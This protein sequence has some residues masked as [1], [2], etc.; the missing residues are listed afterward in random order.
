MDESAGIVDV[1]VPGDQFRYLRTVDRPECGLYTVIIYTAQQ[2]AGRASETELVTDLF[3]DHALVGGE[4]L[5]PPHCGI[6]GDL[7][8]Y[9][10]ADSACVQPPP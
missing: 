3:L 4:V 1:P 6:D 5:L 10:R 7:P 2:I 9:V 8:G